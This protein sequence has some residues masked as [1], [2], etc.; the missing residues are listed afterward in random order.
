MALWWTSDEHHGHPKVIEYCKRPFSNADEQTQILVANFNSRVQPGDTTYHLGDFS[1]LN[2]EASQRLLASLNGTHIIVLGN[3]DRGPIGMK[4]VGFA[5]VHYNLTMEIDGKKVYMSHMPPSEWDE[6]G[7][8]YKLVFK[9]APP[10][11]CD[12]HLAGHVHEKWARKGKVINVGVDQ[13]NFYPV[14]FDELLSTP[15]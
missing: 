11:D 8:K 13:R 3:H 12:V 14:S 1:F 4:E 9:Q 7:R 5:E 10:A 15:E 2:K 6:P